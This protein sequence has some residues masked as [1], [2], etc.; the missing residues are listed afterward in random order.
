M[1]Q[2]AVNCLKRRL[3][4]RETNKPKSVAQFSIVHVFFSAAF[5]QPLFAERS[6]PVEKLKRSAER[7]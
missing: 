1:A 6:F 4:E 7:R 3:F 5:A 2:F